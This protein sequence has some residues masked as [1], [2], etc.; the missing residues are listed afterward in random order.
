MNIYSDHKL[1]VCCQQSY[2]YSINQYKEAQCI[3][4]INAGRPVLQTLHHV[5]TMEDP[6]A[7]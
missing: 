5:V 1:S 7:D 4:G 2:H 6:S 3:L